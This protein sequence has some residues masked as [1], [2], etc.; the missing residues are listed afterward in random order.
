M[1][2]KYISV[3]KFCKTITKNK[4]N[5]RSLYAYICSN[6]EFLVTTKIG[7]KSGQTKSIN[8]KNL[9]LLKNNEDLKYFLKRNN[10][11]IVK[12]NVKELE[13]CNNTWGEFKDNSII[14]PCDIKSQNNVEDMY[15]KIIKQEIE[16]AK[17]S[18][19]AEYRKDNQIK[20]FMES[21]FSEIKE[22]EKTLLET[23]LRDRITM[24]DKISQMYKDMENK[25]ISYR[26]MVENLINVNKKMEVI[27]NGN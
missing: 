13:C 24:N 22:P 14:I 16:K 18:I 27:N 23:I 5:T 20:D 8:L 17:P 25:L 11:E 6:L 19:I 3:Y 2:N 26:G 7:A 21:F 15:N 12:S 1:E 10:I 4:T 9:E